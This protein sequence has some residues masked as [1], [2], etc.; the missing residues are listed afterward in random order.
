MGKPMT[1]AEKFR[2]TDREAVLT[3]ALAIAIAAFFWGAVALF[4]DR[5]QDLLWGLP[6]WFS[7]SCLGGYL[8]S[9]AGVAI[10]TRFLMRDFDLDSPDAPADLRQFEGDH[11][12]R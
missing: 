1:Y 2:A 12:G 11:H 7:V 9:V 3:L 5:P 6:L 4:G 10:L 8:L